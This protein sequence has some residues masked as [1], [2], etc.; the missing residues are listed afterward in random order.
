MGTTTRRSFL[1]TAAT[2]S[3]ATAPASHLLAAAANP[4][5]GESRNQPGAKKPNVILLFSDQH[6]KRVMGFEGHPDVM[7]PNLDKLAGQSVVFDRAYCTRGVCVPSRTSLMTGMMPRTLGVLDNGDRPPLLNEAVSMAT[8][9]KYNGYRTFAFG[10]RHLYQAAD[11]GWDVRK[12]DSYRSDEPD[13]YVS[14][15]ERKGYIKEFA[16]DWAAEF[17]RGPKGSSEYN[18]RIPT[19]DLGTRISRLPEGYT[20]EAYTAQETVNMIKGNARDGKPFFCWASFYRPHQPYTPLPK[21]RA[22]Y[23]ASKWGEG[24][25]KGGGIRMPQSLYQPTETLPPMLQ[26]QR[27]GGNK[28][29]NLDQA[30]ANE[31]LWRNHIA[32]YYALV[33]E[34]DHHVGEILKAVKE[35]GIE[36]DTL[37]LYAADHGDFVGNH[38]MVEKCAAGHNVYED[39]LNVPLIIKIPGNANNGKRVTELVT[40]ADVL[41]TLVQVLDLKLP[42]LKYPIQGQSLAKVVTGTGSLNRDYVVSESWSQACV[43]TKEAKLGIMLDPTAAHPQWDFRA[44]GDMFFDTL[45]DPLE[46]DNRIHD[47]RYKQQIDTLRAYYADFVKQTPATGKDQLIR[48]PGN[49]D[50]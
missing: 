24:T 12:G 35:A 3:L 1:Q 4:A 16:S 14:W 30:F 32:A 2:A 33:T 28:V 18:T 13:N 34:I 29:W 11:M 48:A 36:N 22:P 41:P 49:A 40:L 50:V 39:I 7:T 26:S 25:K 9:F 19:A 6:H 23:D 5:S 44:F 17:G 37:V 45:H 42:P 38:G 31:Q 43:I 21:Y 10:K 20:M 27:R 47:E 15:V 8:L 46:V